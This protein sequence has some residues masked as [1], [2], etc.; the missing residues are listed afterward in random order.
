MVTRIYLIGMPGSG[1]SAVGRQLAGVLG[2]PFVDLDAE[3]ELRAG[4]PITRIFEEKGESSFRE[5]E[6]EALRSWASQPKAFVMA[7][8]G[9]APCYHNGM[10]IIKNSG[11]GIFLDVAAHE[12]ATRI[13][14][15]VHRPLIPQKDRIATLTSLLERRRPVY[16]RAEYRIDAARP[17]AEVVAA[18]VKLLKSHSEG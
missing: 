16:E 17:P 3:I 5:I 2:V 6:A 4:M 11:V 7:T 9:G 14:T 10:D 8:G 15:E 18:I 12:L 13:T 1:K